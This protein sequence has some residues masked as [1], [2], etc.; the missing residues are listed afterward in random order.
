M[1]E[2]HSSSCMF[3][4]RE[5]ANNHKADR[6]DTIWTSVARRLWRLSLCMITMIITLSW[7]CRDD[8][9]EHVVLTAMRLHKH[10]SLLAQECAN[11]QHSFRMKIAM[12]NRSTMTI[13]RERAVKDSMFDHNWDCD[14]QLCV[15]PRQRSWQ[16]ISWLS[17][18]MNATINHFGFQIMKGSCHRVGQ[19]L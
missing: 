11:Y 7:F 17:T 10:S 8:V 16:T 1:R 6:W 19:H 12:D 15:W 2:S 18:M 13:P 14:E 5:C 9:H 3:N 4:A